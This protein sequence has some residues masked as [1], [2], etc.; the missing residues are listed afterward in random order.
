MTRFGV[1]DVYEIYDA[2]V[3][4]WL[5]GVAGMFV[6]EE[7]EVVIGSPDRPYGTVD[8][9]LVKAVTTRKTPLVTLTRLS[10]GF[11]HN[12]FIKGIHRRLATRGTN[13]YL[14]SLR[15]VP[16]D[17]PYQIDI[18]ARRRSTANRLLRWITDQFYPVKVLSINFDD[19]WGVIRHHMML[20]QIIDNSDLETGENERWIRQTVTTLLESYAFPL[21]DSITELDPDGYLKLVPAVKEIA[22][23][24]QHVID[25]ELVLV[26]SW[27]YDGSGY[28]IGTGQPSTK[29]FIL[30]EQNLVE[31]LVAVD[32]Q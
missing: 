2:S 6:G 23:D 20:G 24:V 1:R 27:L 10:T 15:P 21:M 3:R 28:V 32:I 13:L 31:D 8:E 22:V 4:D 25:D 30:L 9:D 17:I 18:R 26:S 11:Q 29:S 14:Q 19:P 7:F 12:R 5:N 16:I